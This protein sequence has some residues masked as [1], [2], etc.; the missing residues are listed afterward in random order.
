ME[1]HIVLNTG[2]GN[3]QVRNKYPKEVISANS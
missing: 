1:K 2:G 3:C